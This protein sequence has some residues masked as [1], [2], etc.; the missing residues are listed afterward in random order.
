MKVLDRYNLIDD[1]LEKA[2]YRVC[3]TNEE[4]TETMLAEL[5]YDLGEGYGVCVTGIL[6]EDETF[7]CESL[8]PYLIG[9]EVSTPE[10]VSVEE[11]LQGHSFAGVVDDLN[12][13]STLIFH[14]LNSIDFLKSGYQQIDIIPGSTATLSAL[15]AEGMVVL[16][17]SKTDQEKQET[18]RRTGQRRKL[19]LKARSGDEDAMQDLSMQDMEIYASVADRL[20]YD[21]V[22]TL[23]DSYFMPTGAECDLYS[24]MGEIVSCRLT[25]NPYT[26]EKVW[27]LTV[28]CNELRFDVC[29]N[30]MDLFG[31]PVPGRRFKGVIWMQGLLNLPEPGEKTKE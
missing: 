12:I 26:L 25:E 27:I 5:R 6:C 23:V 21:D 20:Q 10:E 28:T 13:G 3:T 19:I 11:K 30:Q 2:G 18:N 7:I 22:F 31:Q 17:L 8:Y 24:V 1:V 15:S 4:D 9:S 14:L 16:P 29:I